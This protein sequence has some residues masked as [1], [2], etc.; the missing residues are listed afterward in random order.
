MRNKQG[1]IRSFFF[2]QKHRLF[3]APEII[4]TIESVSKCFYISII[5]LLLSIISFKK[6]DLTHAQVKLLKEIREK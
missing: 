5:G 6:Y 3:G 2:E 4:S 1:T